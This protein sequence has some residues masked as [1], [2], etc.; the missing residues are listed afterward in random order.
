MSAFQK[1]LTLERGEIVRQQTRNLTIS[2]LGNPNTNLLIVHNT[3]PDAAND[4]P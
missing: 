1:A 4:G 3:P 2:A